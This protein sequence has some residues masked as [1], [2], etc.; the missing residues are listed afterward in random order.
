MTIWT[1]R[2]GAAEFADAD[3]VTDGI[4]FDEARRH[5]AAVRPSAVLTSTSYGADTID[6]AFFKAA[7]AD[8]VPTLGILDAWVHYRERLTDGRG[9]LVHLPDRLAVMDKRAA[10]E[11]VDLGFPPDR[12]DVVGLTRLARL[13]ANMER[14]QERDR[15]ARQHGLDPSSRWIAFIS[16]AISEIHGSSERARARLGRLHEPHGVRHAPQGQEVGLVVQEERYTTDIDN[17]VR[18]T[19]DW[20]NGGVQLQLTRI[21]GLE[22]GVEERRYR[23]DPDEES[24]DD[25]IGILLDRDTFSYQG[26]FR[27]AVTP[28]TTIVAS[29]IPVVRP[30]LRRR[31]KAG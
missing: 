16:Q 31:M 11:M 18:R 27:Y 9:P 21:V 24:E 12:L 26:R 5:L 10:E 6:K 29:A 2:Y 3:R 15:L 19:E 1:H 14:S 17:R 7:R 22:F 28:L 8:G 30:H 20:L 23:F 4:T 13:P 25:S